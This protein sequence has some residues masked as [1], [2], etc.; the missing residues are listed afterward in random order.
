MTIAAMNST[1]PVMRMARLSGPSQENYAPKRVS[2]A[3]PGLPSALATTTA[4]SPL[5]TFQFRTCVVVPELVTV[6]NFWLAGAGKAATVPG[7]RLMVA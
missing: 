2:T 5:L 1:T 6:Q 7:V 4:Q 3:T